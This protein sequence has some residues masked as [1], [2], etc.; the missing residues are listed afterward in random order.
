MLVDNL[1]AFTTSDFRSVVPVYF[2][3]QIQSRGHNAL[4]KHASRMLSLRYD[5]RARVCCERACSPSPTDSW[6]AVESVS[7]Q[8]STACL[9]LRQS[10]QHY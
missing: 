2:D 8:S 10:Q 1:L 9:H 7:N 6:E 4:R 3:E 5:T